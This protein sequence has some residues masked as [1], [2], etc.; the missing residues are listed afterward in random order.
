MR[1]LHIRF[2]N[3]NS[4]VGEWMI[5]LTHPAFR[6][7]GIFAITGATG[8]GKTTILDAICLAL[9]GRTPRLNK[10]TKSEN[11]IMSRQTGECFA[12]IAFETS[13]GRYRCHWSQTRARR[14]PD[15]T[16]QSPKH[17]IVDVD[18]DKVLDAKIRGVAEQI[19]LTT[20]MSFERFTRSML[21]AQGGFAAFLQAAPDERSPILEQ[22]TGTEI[23][24]Q[25][26]IGV[27]ERRAEE[28]NKLDGLLAALA[29]MPL[30]SDEEEQLLNH[31]LEEKKVQERDLNQQ[32][33]HTSDA[34]AW[35]DRLTLLNSELSALEAQ[36]HT[37][38]ERH[39]AF[40]PAFKQLERA[41]Q[42]MELAAEHA[43]LDA[44]RREQMSSAERL[45]EL[46]HMLPDKVFEVSRAEEKLAADAGE[47]EHIQAEQKK[48]L[49]ILQKAR[50]LDLK[51]L[52]KA[53]FIQTATD[54]VTDLEATLFTLRA[55][56]SKHL[57]EIED[58]QA[59]LHQ[60][61]A[62]LL[63][64]QADEGLVEH[65][66]GIKNRF[67]VIRALD[68]KVTQK[69]R[70]LQASKL[71][72]KRVSESWLAQSASLETKKK[73]VDEALLVFQQHQ[74]ALNA[75]L[76]GR[77]VS[78]WR[79]YHKTLIERQHVLSQTIQSVQDVNESTRMLDTLKVR[80]DTFTI[81]KDQLTCQIEEKETTIGVFDREV[82][83]LETQRLLIK[84]IHDLDLARLQLQD[85][86]ACPLCGATEHPFAEG[87]IP[88][89]DES[90][91][92]LTQAKE[93][94]KLSSNRLSELKI[95][96]AEILKDL[97]HT[98]RDQ[99]LLKDKIE[100]ETVKIKNGLSVL[101]VMDSGHAVAD[102][103]Q[104]L[105]N[106][107]VN[108][109]AHVSAVVNA[110][111]E[112]ETNMCEGRDSLEASKAQLLTLERDNQLLLHQKE[113]SEQAVVRETLELE[114]ITDEL[115]KAH[116]EALR[117]VYPYGIQHL[118]SSLLE[119]VLL[120]LNTRRREWLAAQHQKAELE[121]CLSRLVLQAQHQTEVV[122]QREA[123]LHVQRAMLHDLVLQRDCL[124]RERAGLLSDQ[125]P[126]EEEERLAAAVEAANQR[127]DASRQLL[128]S[129]SQSCM[130]LKQSMQELEHIK[131]MRE[132][133]L[134]KLERQF[135]VRLS[136]FG[137]V[138]ESSYLVA[139]LNENERKQLMQQAQQL[140][141]EKTEVET[142][143]GDKTALLKCENA[144]QVTVKSRD[145]LVQEQNDW[146]RLQ[147]DLQQDMGAM[148]QKLMD[149][150]TLGKKHR[151]R[152]V[153]I[154][155]QKIE[156]LRWETLHGLIGS[157]DGKKY[158]N[159]AQG[160]TFE[161]MIGHANRQLQKMTDRYLLIRDDTQ[162]LELNVIDSYQAGDIR[163]TKNLSGGEGFIVSLSLALGLSHMASKNVRL[164]S[165][166]LDEGFGTLDEDALDTALE[167][168][169]GLQQEGKLIGVISHVTMLK[170]R[171]STQIRVTHQAG[172]QSVLSGPGCTQ[173]V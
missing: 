40:E 46:T 101:S 86:E 102:V 20:G 148:L 151:E 38:M 74:E 130:Q 16:L 35:C 90:N 121:A 168:L 75:R 143:I 144:K 44:L 161:M 137:F 159:F 99:T 172:G 63:E 95:Q 154:D 33:K 114:S 45:R 131:A 78:D 29:G 36:Q 50:E 77:A 27:H 28:R 19:E 118:S 58:N 103:L 98:M 68:N 8:A 115:Q 85:G 70:V 13:S 111:D 123:E 49:P 117:D 171:I 91:L 56:H 18:S 17:E 79:E 71:E 54:T 138:D 34:I 57:R 108:E 89:L 2:K 9:Y 106:E 26:S 128:H 37:L 158:R 73:E 12:E 23:Y 48:R 41:N 64:Y 93:R 62:F 134:N 51:L 1:I 3:L 83:L 24:S 88:P 65:L 105:Q 66:A 142:R 42:C 147:R 157:M 60:L 7:E 100:V 53:P 4:L 145:T 59:K 11:D 132:E 72:K 164:D 80:L 120:D 15:G 107:T 109:L 84:R 146:M 152:L 160:L 166:F 21:L 97:A 139:V 22:I 32:I 124:Q 136:Q 141:S 76:G 167:T 52:D 170:E 173:V 82:S 67:E 92:A 5:D 116:D 165:L 30:L 126:D 61:E 129:I 55:A 113:I 110:M 125:N 140:L 153:A 119:S 112:H 43:G 47:V 6:S 87:N 94:L 169:S 156:L 96:H 14:K 135:Q 162:P 69:T 10:V 39:H 81:Q 31:G 150:E 122:A 127:L 25:I 149:N 104:R 155:A 163:S 133:E